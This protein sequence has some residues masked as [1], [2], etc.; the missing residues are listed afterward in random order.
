MCA[1]ELIPIAMTFHTIV[2]QDPLHAVIAYSPVSLDFSHAY[3][4]AFFHHFMSGGN[5]E[6]T[7]G[8]LMTA[9]VIVKKECNHFI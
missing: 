1:R 3:N 7:Q 6:A 5:D 8:I 4:P 9:L 2:L